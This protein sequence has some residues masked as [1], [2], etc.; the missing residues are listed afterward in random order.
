MAPADVTRA[1]HAAD[2]AMDVIAATQVKKTRFVTA[3]SEIARNV[4]VHG[5]GGGARICCAYRNGEACVEATFTDQGPGI[6]DIELA[7]R[8][9]YTTAKGLGLGLGGAKRLVDGFDIRSAAGE[10][11]TIRL[12]SR[13]K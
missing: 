3:V 8:N 13:A 10:G 9:G 12:S 2:H 5:G 4:I 6:P 1:R 7:M 11:V